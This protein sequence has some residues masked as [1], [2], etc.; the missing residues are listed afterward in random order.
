MVDADRPGRPGESTPREATRTHARESTLEPTSSVPVPLG[1]V[2][3]NRYRIDGVL[4]SGGMGVVV[5]ATHLALQTRV[6]IKFLKPDSLKDEEARAR[7]F[8][9]ARA[10]AR[11][12]GD[13]VVQIID[14]G[15][16]E[17]GAPYVVMEYLQGADLATVL[18]ANGP[19][20]VADAA[21]YVLQVCEAVHH[22]HALGIVHRDLKPSNVFLTRD[23]AGHERIKVLDF[24]LSKIV[25]VPGGP[26]LDTRLTGPHSMLG[27]PLYMSPEQLS[28]ASDV[29][30]RTDIWSIG[31]IL[32]QLIAGR[33]PFEAR[34][35]PQLCT[36]IMHGSP[37]S[38]SNLRA[39]VPAGL[40]S[41]I[42]RCLAKKLPDRYANVEELARALAR[43]MATPRLTWL[44]EVRR[45]RAVSE[46]WQVAA[47]CGAIMLTAAGVAAWM[48]F[49]RS[50]PQHTAALR[51]S[52]PASVA[53][54]RLDGKT[55]PG[56]LNAG[57]VAADRPVDGNGSRAGLAATRCSVCIASN[58]DPEYQACRASPACE[59]ALQSYNK[60]VGKLDGSL[61]A[62]CSETFGT[63]PDRS[64]QRLASCAFVAMGGPA[65]EPGRCTQECID[66]PISVNACAGYCNCMA[67]TCESTMPPADCPSLCAKLSPAQVRC[68]TYHCFL[69][70]Q[71]QPELHC[72]HAI[73]RLNMCP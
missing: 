30:H 39:D 44:D 4:G 70:S 17:S 33:P 18:R 73:G 10:A 32:F 9:E 37:R 20:P 28:N 52:A 35:L 63:D 65:V 48:G 66:Q 61:D 1:H 22:A 27:T 25:D 50:A 12:K 59:R 24:G 16:L 60:C 55:V 19:L 53:E 13:H 14:V 62:S 69:G 5:A 23:A 46:Q 49:A 43:F 6:A 45:A 7:L 21:A 38:L 57:G 68:R 40:E 15:T 47:A 36:L 31:A 11:T 29:D 71:T 8:R 41:V 64:A 42:S 54:P 26:T 2:L 34:S 3:A 72:Q 56:P 67:Q 58:C 51:S